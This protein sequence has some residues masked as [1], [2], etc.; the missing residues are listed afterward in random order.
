LDDLLASG[1]AV[2]VAVVPAPHDPDSFIRERGGEAFRRIVEEAK[3]FFE[4]YL[5]R[6]CALNDLRTDRGRN[7]VV[8]AMAE[9]AHKTGDSMLIDRC[10]RETAARLGVSA[11][12]GVEQFKKFRSQPRRPTT[13]TE[14]A[15]APTESS[16]SRPSPQESWLVKLLLLDDKLVAWAAAHLEPAWVQHPLVRRVVERR[17]ALQAQEAWQN[18]AAFLSEFQDA[19]TQQLIT[20]AVSEKREIRNRAQQLTDVVKHLRDQHLERQ[21]TELTRQIAEPALPEAQRLVLVQRQDTLLRAQRE[22]LAPLSS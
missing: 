10:A 16:G 3:G 13:Q 22:P 15:Q 2:R 1:L 11:A 5:D 12:S 18:V 14:P 20:E 19:S 21:I 7:A 9:A 17:L 6:L 4:Y 8:H